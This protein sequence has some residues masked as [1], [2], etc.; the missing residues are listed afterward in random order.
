[1][2]AQILTTDDLYQFKLDLLDE[3]RALFGQHQQSLNKP[4]LKSAEVLRLLNISPSTLQ[5]LRLTG[6]LPFTKIGGT[7][8]FNADEIE[9]ILSK[10]M[11]VKKSVL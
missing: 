5:H 7:L 8:Y 3:L 4:W 1:M 10:N 2:P 9:A 6:T 11:H